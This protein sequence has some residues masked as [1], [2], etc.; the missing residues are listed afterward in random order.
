MNKYSFTLAGSLLAILSARIYVLAWGNLSYS[1]M[2]YQLHH[3]YYG[4]GLLIVAGILKRM[5]APES[6]LF[7][8]IGLGLGYIFDEFDLLLSVG[9]TYTMQLYNA[10][11]NLAMDVILVLVLLRLNENRN[12]VHGLLRDAETVL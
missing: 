2:G 6:L 3:F 4:L 5:K 11:L 7:F 12:Y 1:F 8:V 10:P 9:H